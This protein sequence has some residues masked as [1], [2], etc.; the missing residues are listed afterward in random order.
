MNAHVEK[1]FK[2]ECGKIFYNS[3]SFNG[4]KSHCKEHLIT[5]G[6]IDRYN[7]YLDKQSGTA[8]AARKARVSKLTNKKQK[9]DQIWLVAK[10]TCERCGKV[11]TEKF[12]S[13]RFCSR[14][15]ANTRMLSE[16]TKEKIRETLDN[17]LKVKEGKSISSAK[18]CKI[19]GKHI[20]SYN[21]TGFCANCLNNTEEGKLA[22]SAS[23]KKGYKTMLENGT[24]KGWQSRNIT[25]Y[26]EQFWIDVLDN[27]SISYE[28]EVPV[29]H[30]TANY[31]LDFKLIVAGKLIDLEIDGKQHTY[32]DRAESDKIRD[33]FLESKDYIVYRIPWNEISSEQGKIIMQDKINKFL[34]FY[35]SL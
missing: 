2:C 15:C 7:L 26:A 19:C 12:G 34:E 31:F 8:D 21:K 6:G 14:A 11:M 30:G 9:E 33:N 13:G 10:H 1:E 27:N 17:T 20:K 5:K 23:G 24:H 22:L 29:W 16:E 4:H 25:S 28:R 3:Q 35:K 32:E 18:Y